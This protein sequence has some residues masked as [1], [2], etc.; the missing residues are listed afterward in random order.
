MSRKKQPEAEADLDRIVE[1][2]PAEELREVVSWA[3]QWH[4]DVERRVRLI[5]A[6]SSGDLRELRVEVDRGLRTRRFLGYRESVEWAR[7]ARPVITEF[8]AAVRAAPS[9][10]LVE[11]LERG[12]AHVVKVIQHRRTTRPGWSV[13]SRGIC[14]RFMR[15]C[16]MPAGGGSGEAR[17]VDDPVPVRRS[18]LL[19]GRPGALSRR[20]RRG[21]ARGVPLAPGGT[22]GPG[23]VFAARYARERLA[24]LDGDSDAIVALLGG[25]SRGRTSSSGSPR[26][27]PSSAAMT[28]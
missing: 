17:A 3:A 20:A 13:I 4:E 7:A 11:L 2:L 18:G 23:G 15:R 19:R 26:R 22:E 16:V 27:W 12:V 25:D 8:E 10:D 21:R 1:Q 14:W 28:R 9:Q 6:R 5:A 24:V